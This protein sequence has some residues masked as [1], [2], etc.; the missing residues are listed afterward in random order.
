MFEKIF[1]ISIMILFSIIFYK[2]GQINEI[3]EQRRN[4]YVGT[5]R[6]L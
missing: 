6:E 3:K 5:K 4:K 1:T 2:L